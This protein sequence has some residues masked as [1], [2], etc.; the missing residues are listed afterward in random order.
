MCAY[1]HARTHTRT[2]SHT[3]PDWNYRASFANQTPPGECIVWELHHKIKHKN[4]PNDKKKKS[5]CGKQP[6]KEHVLL[7]KWPLTFL[8]QVFT[9]PLGFFKF[10]FYAPYHTQSPQICR[11]LFLYAEAQTKI[12]FFSSLCSTNFWKTKKTGREQGR[13]GGWGVSTTWLNRQHIFPGYSILTPGWLALLAS[14]QTL[15]LSLPLSSA[16]L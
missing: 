13:N 1:V 14:P 11:F 10:F 4:S 12:H 2:H 8:A 15:V 6:Q 7:C 9:S 5:L 16:A 3:Q